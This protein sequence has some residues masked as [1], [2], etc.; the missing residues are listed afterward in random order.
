MDPLISW[1][2]LQYAGWEKVK[3][4]LPF[5]VRDYNGVCA[6]T[7]PGTGT[8]RVLFR[9]NT[10]STSISSC[11]SFLQSY[12][13]FTLFEG[14]TQVCASSDT[15][16]GC[17]NSKTLSYNIDSSMNCNTS[18]A[19]TAGG[20]ASCLFYITEG[21]T[22]YLTLYNNDAT[23]DDSTTYQTT[24][25]II[26]SIN[27]VATQY[28]KQCLDDQNT[29]YVASPGASVYLTL[30]AEAAE[31]LL[32]VIGVVLFLLLII[33]MICAWLLYRKKRRDDELRKKL[34]LERAGDDG[35]ADEDDKVNTRGGLPPGV[36]IAIMEG[37]SRGL[38]DMNGMPGFRES[39]D[40]TPS[41]IRLSYDAPHRRFSKRRRV[42]VI[43]DDGK[44][45]KVWKERDGK[46][47][48]DSGLEED[49]ADGQGGKGAGYY[50]KKR[51]EKEERDFQKQF[52]R[53]DVKES[54]ELTE[55]GDLATT[56]T[57]MQGKIKKMAGVRS[58]AKNLKKR[59]RKSK[60]GKVYEQSG[61]E[62]TSVQKGDSEYSTDEDDDDDDNASGNGNTVGGKEQDQN[63][64][65][66]M[67]ERRERDGKARLAAGK[68]GSGGGPGR[69]VVVVVVA[70]EDT[71]VVAELGVQALVEEKMVVVVTAD[72]VVVVVV[73]EEQEEE[74]VAGIV[75]EEAQTV[76]V[77]AVEVVV[78]L[79]DVIQVAV[80][81]VMLEVLEVVLVEVS[82]EAGLQTPV[83]LQMTVVVVA[84]VVVVVDMLMDVEGET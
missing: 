8:Y 45:V 64:Q 52:G 21:T 32:W 39:G 6:N 53:K 27:L 80:M 15:L 31:S 30:T 13:S 79:T 41:G 61:Q 49:E 48:P 72:E 44:V 82:V 1:M 59:G 78:E 24:C 23:V 74:V 63:K 69:V 36:T 65:N 43:G 11:P 19:Y 62:L 66:E 71:A 26:D 50:D 57:K 40:V 37:R 54:T 76:M 47:S 22:T 14:G 46:E 2:P 18:L 16:D 77:V 9:N 20:E 70:M 25:M 3:M 38:K 12:Y 7:N 83:T 73:E 51:K 35:R 55:K 56:S 84:V 4:Y 58:Y 28:P 10:L 33:A 42:W 81:E 29:T 60:S 34:E 17:A 5:S 75:V 67:K 68:G